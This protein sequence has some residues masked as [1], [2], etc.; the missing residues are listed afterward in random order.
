M[1]H[2]KVFSLLALMLSALGFVSCSD[3]NGSNPVLDG[4]AKPTTFKLNT[5]ALTEQYIQL[6][7]DNT[8]NLQWSQPDYGFAAIATYKVQVGVVENGV[9]KWNVKADANGAETP[10]YLETSYTKC[11]ADISGEEIAQAICAIDGFTDA[12]N[13]VDKGFR[14]IAF[15]IHASILDEEGADIPV[16]EI[17]SNP[18]TFKNMA[19]YFAVKTK[20]YFYIIGACNGWTGPDEA[21]AES[22]KP[23]RIYETAIGSKIYEGTYTITAGNFQFRFYAKLTGWDGGDS[24][25]SQVDDAPIAISLDNDTYSGPITKGKGS[26]QIGDWAT[27][28]DVKITID[29]NKGTVK[30]VKQ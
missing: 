16:T 20:D 17:V 7:A 23:W 27:D 15:R 12:D 19:A 3:D 14:E 10:Q 28:A 5:P 22:L 21:N 1:K 4:S 18:V 24:Y 30:F 25:G 2:I 26:W 11:S 9:T 6:S 8:V 13:Y 29:M